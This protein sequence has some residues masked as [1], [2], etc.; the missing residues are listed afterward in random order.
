[1]EIKI[2]CSKTVDCIQ[3][4]MKNVSPCLAI[5]VSFVPQEGVQRTNEKAALI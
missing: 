2:N 3:L 5:F 4:E 1:M